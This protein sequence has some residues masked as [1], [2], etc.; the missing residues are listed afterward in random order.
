MH[1]GSDA[2]YFWSSLSAAQ[3]AF[4][5]R[6]ADLEF[7]FLL[8]HLAPGMRVVDLG[9]GAGSITC[10]IAALV[11]PGEVRGVDTSE[12]AIAS[13]QSLAAERG[14]D[15]VTF[16]VGDATDTHLAAQSFDIVII[17]VM[18]SYLPEPERAVAEAFRLLKPGGLYAG[19]EMMKAGDWF[20]GPHANALTEIDDM[21]IEGMREQGGDPFFGKR[22]ARILIDNGFNLIGARSRYSDVG[23]SV[24][25]IGDLYMSFLGSPRGVEKLAARGLV[26]EKQQAA[27]KREVQ[28]WAADEGSLVATAEVIALGKK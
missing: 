13:A 5:R 16:H 3:A 4:N 27:R 28:E 26:T 12:S 2:Q 14:L 19:R 6:R 25:L 9:C 24:S 11:A 22:L 7:D 10:D 1:K 15:N 18:L 8:S 21:I 17:C 20:A 23:S